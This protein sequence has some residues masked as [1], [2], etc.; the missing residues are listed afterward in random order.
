MVKA[1]HVPESVD[2]FEAGK[3]SAS[4]DQGGCGACWAF[5]TATTMESLNAI[6]NDL[7]E[8]PVYSV[9]H[10]IDCDDGNWGC[11]GGWMADSYMWTKDNG[12][13][14]W[15]DYAHGY[16]GRKAHCSKVKKSVPK[17]YNKESNE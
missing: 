12:V 13:I 15:N 4:V 7:D 8:V 2:W 5:T 16:Q 9:Q 14:D 17:F 11:D 6:Q 10:L 1:S 3:V